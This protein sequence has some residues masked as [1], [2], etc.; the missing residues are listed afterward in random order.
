[1]FEQFVKYCYLFFFLLI[2]LGFF[3]NGYY[4]KEN[5]RDVI[6]RNKSSEQSI[7]E[8][9]Y[10]SLNSQNIRQNLSSDPYA[11]TTRSH[12]FQ[13]EY[14]EAERNAPIGLPLGLPLPSGETLGER[15]GIE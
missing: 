11:G 3:L 15:L 12:K 1:M 5:W 7:N 14:E 2:T 9:N 4:P 8:E 13:Q 6:F 10:N